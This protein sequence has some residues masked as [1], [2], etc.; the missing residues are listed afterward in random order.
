MRTPK[1][2]PGVCGEPVALKGARRVREAVRG[3]PPTET[4]AGRPEPTSPRPRGDRGRPLVPL[5]QAVFGVWR[6]HRVDAAEHPGVQVRLRRIPRPRR[7]RGTEHPR[8]R[9]GGE[10]KRL[11]SWC[12][13]STRVLSDEATGSEAG[14]PTGDGWNPLPF[15]EERK[16]TPQRSP[17]PFGGGFTK[18]GGRP[19]AR[20]SRAAASASYGTCSTAVSTPCPPGAG[21]RRLRRRRGP[22]RARPPCRR[23]PRR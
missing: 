7:E 13:T 11:W 12:K 6:A 2:P 23:R 10:V 4:S 17:S 16:S 19:G 14:R 15:R 9:A 3:N 18:S 8:R 5:L 22:R 21:R 20:V 1:S